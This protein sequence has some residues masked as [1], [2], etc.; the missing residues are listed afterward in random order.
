MELITGILMV[1][2]G[3]ISLVE[4]M[5]FLSGMIYVYGIIAVI[6]GIVDIVFGIRA[7]SAPVPG[8][9]VALVTGTV[10]LMAGTMLI[11]SPGMGQWIIAFLFPIWFIAHCIS[12]LCHAGLIRA[13]SGNGVY[14]ATVV[15]NALGLIL[16]VLMACSPKYA[17]TSAAVLIG[18]FLIILGIQSVIIGCIVLKNSNR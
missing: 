5:D 8:S 7:T 14:T 10:S 13:V 9:I 6:T 3:I 4:P 15:L 1:I 2:L 11:I 12:G 18:L 16:A 17:L